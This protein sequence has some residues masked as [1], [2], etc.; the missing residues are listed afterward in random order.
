MVC[1]YIDTLT[2]S[3][4]AYSRREHFHG[5]NDT[6]IIID[7][8]RHVTHPLGSALMTRSL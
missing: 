2:P 3:R 4:F 7:S 1:G 8:D 6:V 5:E